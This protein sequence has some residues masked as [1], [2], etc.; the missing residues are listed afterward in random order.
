MAVKQLHYI[1]GD[2][3]RQGSYVVGFGENSP[4]RHHHRSSNCAPWEDLEDRDVDG[5]PDPCAKYASSI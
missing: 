4:Q 5:A 3:D 1:A 2:N